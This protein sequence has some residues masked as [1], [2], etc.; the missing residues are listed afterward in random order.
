MNFNAKVL[1]KILENQIQQYIKKIIHHDQEG[2]IP[3]MQGWLSIPKHLTAVQHIN[4]SKEKNHTIISI[5]AEEA[6]N[7]IQHHFI[8]KAP[9]KLG[10]ERMFLT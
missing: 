5:D 6:F 2:F 7:K 8:I 10:T 9:M 1:N 4:R 3:E